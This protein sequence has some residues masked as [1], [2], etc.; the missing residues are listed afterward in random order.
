MVYGTQRCMYLMSSHAH[1]LSEES[2][3]GALWVAVAVVV[4]W[5]WTGVHPGTGVGAGRGPGA[6]GDRWVDHLSTTVTCELFITYM[7]GE[8]H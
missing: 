6:T 2:T 3:L 5:V 1:L 7:Y 8:T 4:D